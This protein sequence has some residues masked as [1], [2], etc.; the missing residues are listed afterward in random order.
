MDWG[1]PAVLEDAA[2][3]GQAQG[4]GDRAST[5]RWD[6]DGASGQERWKQSQGELLPGSI[7][8]VKGSLK[9]FQGN[10]P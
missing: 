3:H 2:G 10:L 5:A 9:R 4:G 8:W 6:K 7:S 1:S